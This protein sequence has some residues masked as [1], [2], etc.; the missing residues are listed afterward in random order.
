M[1]AAEAEILIIPGWS[2]S[3]EDHWQ[4]RW[5]RSLK[6]ARRVLQEDWYEPSLEDWVGRL[7][8]EVENSKLPAVLVAHSLGVVTAIHAAPT[9]PAGKVAGAFLVAPADI[10]NAADWP[11]T[12]GYDPCRSLHGFTPI[13]RARLPFPAMLV[14]SAND[15]YCRLE[16]ARE[17]ATAWGAEFVEAGECGHLNVNSGHGP[18]PEGLLRFGRFLKELG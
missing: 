5:Q 4:S 17:L 2:G 15:P 7:R 11:L 1:R 8:A 12:R 6:S 13:P 18:W 3:E 9:L 16:R 10:E 14:A